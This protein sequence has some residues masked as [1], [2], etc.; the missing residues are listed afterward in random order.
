MDK[1]ALS[2]YLGALFLFGLNGVVASKIT[3]PSYD[4]VFFRTLIGSVFLIITYL[5]IE[6]RFTFQHHRRDLGFI[7]LLGIAMG[8]SWMFLFEGY[9]QIGV[10]I[11]SL[12]TTVVL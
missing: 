1:L 4:I 9:K 2:K 11:S 5:L 7:S 8:L 3:I 6:K 10:G 12:L